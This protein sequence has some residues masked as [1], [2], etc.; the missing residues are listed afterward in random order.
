VAYSLNF[1]AIP[2]SPLGYL[3]TWPDGITQP[4]VSTLN[5]P[6]GTVTANAAL[7]RAGTHGDIDVF[8]TADTDLVMD[9]NGYFADPESAANPQSLYTLTPCRVLDTRQ[10]T[11]LFTGVLRPPVEMAASGCGI[12]DMAQA[13]VL[14]ATVVPSGPMG[15]LTL[16]PDGQSEPTVSTLNARD[17]MT[18]SNMAIVP[19]TD[20]SVDAFASG[21][22]NLIL[23]V[24]GFFAQ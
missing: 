11:G 12:P 16:W 6:T 9:V 5:A 18:T 2:R 22:T 17:G 4:T 21:M 19:V 8:V 15:Y 10:T 20:M 24:F 13:V 14:N 23:D 7:L 1:T 3:T